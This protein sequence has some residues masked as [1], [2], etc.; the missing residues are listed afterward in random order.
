MTLRV[1][2][3]NPGNAPASF[4]SLKTDD[5]EAGPH[6]WADPLVR[7]RSSTMASKE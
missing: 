5:V 7:L 4:L 2:E 3:M 1:T 6:Q